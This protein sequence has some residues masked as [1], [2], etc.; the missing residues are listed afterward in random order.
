MTQQDIKHS[1][2]RGKN[3]TPYSATGFCV[4]SGCLSIGSHKSNMKEVNCTP[5]VLCENCG[6]LTQ[7]CAHPKVCTSAL[8]THHDNQWEEIEKVVVY[9]KDGSQ[10][11]IKSPDERVTNK[12]L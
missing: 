4:S 3:N 7:A 5:V 12:D 10:R 6:L 2:A 1:C 9:Y 8:T 11:T